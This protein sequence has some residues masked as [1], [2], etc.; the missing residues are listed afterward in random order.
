M[1][2]QAQLWRVQRDHEDEC[3]ITLLCDA[4]QYPIIATI[5]AQELLKVTIEV[6]NG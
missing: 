2:F 4:S 6:Q 3:K 1:E 5:P